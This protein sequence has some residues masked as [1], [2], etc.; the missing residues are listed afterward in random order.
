M[1]SLETLLLFT[2][3]VT[4]A[5]L[6]VPLPEAVRWLRLLAPLAPLIAIAQVLVEGP[7][8]EMAAAYVLTGLFFLVW[9]VG[10]VVPAGSLVCRLLT[11]RLVMGAGVGLAAFGLVVSIASPLILPVFRFPTPG[12]PYGIG[13]VT[14]H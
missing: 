2:N 6:V 10:Q 4:L 12:G 11:N 14:Y 8:W 13:T 1:R 5:L 7:R 3:L 9:L